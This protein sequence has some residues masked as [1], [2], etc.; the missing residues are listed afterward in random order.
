MLVL[1]VSDDP[2]QSGRMMIVINTIN[3]TLGFYQL[4]CYPS[5]LI[6]NRRWK[7]KK[8]YCNN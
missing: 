1:T 2:V 4:P 6:L 7:L 5:M 3:I 8:H